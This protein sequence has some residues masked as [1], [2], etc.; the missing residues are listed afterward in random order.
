MIFIC[1]KNTM[2]KMFST[3]V[4]LLKMLPLLSGFLRLD[5]I[6]TDDVM[7]ISSAVMIR[8]HSGEK[9]FEES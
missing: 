5:L 1:L 2:E 7:E 4:V 6:S 9:G 8:S 3:W